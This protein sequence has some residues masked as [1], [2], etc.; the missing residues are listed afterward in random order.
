M[1]DSEGRLSGAHVH[2]TFPTA[3]VVKAML[4]VAYLRGLHSQGRRSVDSNSNSI[5][6]PMIHVSDNNAATA[7]GS[8]VGNRNLYALARRAGMTDFSVTVSWISALLSPAGRSSRT[9]PSPPASVS[10]CTRSPGSSVPITPL[11]WRA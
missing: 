8:I 4:L 7:V 2:W 5:P 1:I 9:A 11:R 10:S 6:Y 3:S